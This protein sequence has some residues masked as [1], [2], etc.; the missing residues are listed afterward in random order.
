[1]DI[2]VACEYSGIVREAFVR[3]GHRAMSCDILPTE[4]PGE[5]YQGDVRDVLYSDWDMVIGFPPCTRLSSVGARYWPKWRA[6]GSQQ[7]AIDFFMLFA[8]HP[9]SKVV[10]ENPAGAMSKAW[11]K[12]DQYVNP[13]QF[14]H[15]WKKR[16]G[17]WL[18]GVPP[19]VPTNVVVPQGHWVDGGTMSKG[20]RTGRSEGAYAGASAKSNGQRAKER[21]KTFQGLADA[22][23]AQWG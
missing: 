3:R 15:P 4:L 5:H 18:K 17:L 22:M 14:G 10:V 1:M 16:T 21:A 9:A 12:A 8:N 6:D 11:R 23:A 2:L 7:E 13:W 20:G 19:L